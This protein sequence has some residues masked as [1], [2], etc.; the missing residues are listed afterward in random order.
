MTSPRADVKDATEIATIKE[1]LPY[2]E[3][4]KPRRTGLKLLGI[5]VF[6]LVFYFALKGQMTKALGLQDTTELHQ[7][8]NEARD[9]VQLEGADNWFFG[10]VLG[11][12]ADALNAVVLF[13][14]E[15]ISIPAFPR[16][17]PEIGW[18][19]GRR[20]GGVDHLRLRR[21]ALDHPGHR[22]AALLRHR[23]PVVG[24]HGHAHHHPAR[25]RDLHGD[26]H[27]ARHLDGSQQTPLSNAVT[28][29]LDIMQ[30]FPPFGYLAPLALF[31]GIGATSA[32]VLTIIYALPPIVRITEHGI[33]SVSPTTQE[34]ARAP[35]D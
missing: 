2:V 15:L 23:R 11:A 35:W 16:P 29:V 27:P 14:Q 13:F 12:I 31:F 26:R 9:W 33:A 17:V 34:A 32:M 25:G 30:T 22:H 18:L 3:Q 4:H 10:G 5:L 19:G 1:Q 8:L 6:W 7:R 24:Q 28:P 21:A 20:P